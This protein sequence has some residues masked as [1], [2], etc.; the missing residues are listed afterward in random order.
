MTLRTR[1][2]A[3]RAESPVSPLPAL[4][5]TIVRSVAPC[6]MSAS[7]RRV[8][9]PAMPN[10]PTRT[11]APSS[12]PATASAASSQIVVRLIGC[13][14]PNRI[15]SAP[16]SRCGMRILLASIDGGLQ[17]QL[18]Y[19]VGWHTVTAGRPLV[20]C[21]LCMVPARDKCGEG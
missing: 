8:G 1:P 15:L 7:I 11:V 10:P 13:P 20:H 19:L 2:A 3:S 12:I 9:I 6:S 21:Q 4:L 5:L 17:Q 16:Y 18:L 14:P